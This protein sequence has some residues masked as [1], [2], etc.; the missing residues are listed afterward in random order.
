MSEFTPTAERTRRAILESGIQVLAANPGASIS[1]IA[2]KAGVSRSTFHRY[3]SDKAA[4]KEA[5][6][7]LTTGEWEAAVNRARLAEGTGLEAFRRLCTELMN[8]LPTLVWWL[9]G[10]DES[11]FA[12]EAEE[13]DEIE[14]RIAAALDRGH[15]D[16]SID[17]QLSVDWIINL[18]WAALYAVYYLPSRTQERL[19]SFE[20]RQ[21]AL[22]SLI[23][24]VAANPIGA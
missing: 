12:D 3:F 4:L 5:A 8:S 17:P 9:S 20:A 10:A 24:S 18:M 6:N 23:K 21:Q 11:N 13:P 14:L 15:T 16:G 22:R 7:S 2:A 1:E 19:G